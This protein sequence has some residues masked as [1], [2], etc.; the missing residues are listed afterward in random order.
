VSLATF[1][2]ANAWLDETKIKFANAADATSLATQADRKVKGSLA[3]L[4]PDNVGQWDASGN[5]EPT[6]AVVRFAASLFMA[7][8]LYQK[9]YSEETG[10]D[11]EFAARLEDRAKGVLTDLREGT[12][13]LDDVDYVS[14]LSF[15]QDDFW[16]N[17]TTVY[18]GTD[19]PIKAFTSDME[20]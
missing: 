9:K 15:A 14:S 13:D 20:F 16:P 8:W 1:E 10:T 3:D 19:L 11:S 12:I 6:P 5:P 18:E 17:D 7:A 4:Y 2:D